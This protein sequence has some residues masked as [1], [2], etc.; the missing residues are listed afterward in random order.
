MAN[1]VPFSDADERKKDAILDAFRAEFELHYVD[2]GDDDT[3]ILSF[4]RY[5]GIS[6]SQ[7]NGVIEPAEGIIIGQVLV[8]EFGCEWCALESNGSRQ[9]AINHEKLPEPL[10]LEVFRWSKAKQI[11]PKRW[12]TRLKQLIPNG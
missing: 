6:D 8:E 7:A 9:L 2:F 1:A 12:F 4:I 5:E 3:A 11:I 10:N